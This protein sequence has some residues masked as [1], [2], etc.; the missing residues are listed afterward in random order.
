VFW[1]LAAVMERYFC[2]STRLK[3]CHGLTWPG[4]PLT[5]QRLASGICELI[6]QKALTAC[7]WLILSDVPPQLTLN[8]PYRPMAAILTGVGALTWW[9]R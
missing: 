8:K 6:I 5:N 7:V 3:A 1:T 4:L 2:A 9:S